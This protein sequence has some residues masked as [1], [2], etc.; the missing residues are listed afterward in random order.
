MVVPIIVM[1]TLGIVLISGQ[2]ATA[3]QY[4]RASRI[5]ELSASVRAAIAVLQDEREQ[6]AAGAPLSR[7]AT[8]TALT[9]TRTAIAADTA[10]GDLGTVAGTAWTTADRQLAELPFLRAETG[11]PAPDRSAMVSAYSQLVDGLFAFDRV[12]ATG[13][14]D[15]EPT[16]QAFALYDLFAAREEVRYQQSMVLAGIGRHAMSVAD[17]TSLHG[18]EARLASRIS[19]FR[20]VASL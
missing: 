13:L 17:V 11:A 19:D 20:A 8:D 18:S 3:G 10:S 16:R 12:L 6:A 1:T 4:A 2:L 5:T 7:T 9:A 15:A 14:T